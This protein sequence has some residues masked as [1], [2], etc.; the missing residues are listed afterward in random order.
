MMEMIAMLM[1][2]NA[3]TSAPKTRIST[4]R[5]AGSPN[6]SSPLVRSDSESSVKSWSRVLVAGDVD[7]ERGV[8]VGGTNLVDDL[9]D[10]GLRVVAE[11][12]GHRCR[13]PV[14]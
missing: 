1:G 7:D 4:I 2:R 12:E 13:V 3:A 5:A 9:H 8:G 11:H 14:L 10:P 6:F